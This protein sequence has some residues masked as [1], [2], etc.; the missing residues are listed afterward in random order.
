MTTTNP[1]AVRVQL[2][3]GLNTPPGWIHVDGS[4][5]ARLAKR[6]GLRK[7]LAA[8]RAVPRSLVDIPWSPDILIHDVRKPLPFADS[9]VDAVYAS[10]LLEHLYRD[11]AERLL[12]ECARVLRP[13]GAVRIVVPDLRAIVGEY[14]GQGPFA[15]RVAREGDGL[16]PEPA[17]D[18]V[19]RRLLLRSPEA[20]RG[21]RVYRLYSAV[22][23]FHSHKWMY[24]ADSL[25]ALMR[26]AGLAEV[27]ERG[28]RDSRIPG[29][30]EVEQPTRVL[31]GEGICV[32]GVRPAR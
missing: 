21:G 25:A 29:I 26:T 15:E 9:S 10:H 13:G 5:N 24:D 11:E 23:D 22:T 28:F 6:P 4:W 7:A 18:R 3:C 19:N 12:K 16:P 1:A 30:D 31:D 20:P 27:S 2:G 8:V 17:A 14:S 32:E